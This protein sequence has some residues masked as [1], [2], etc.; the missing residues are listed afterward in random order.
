[1]RLGSKSNFLVHCK[2][3]KLLF[4]VDFKGPD[5]IEETNFSSAFILVDGRKSSNRLY[6]SN[7]RSPQQHPIYFTAFTLKSTIFYHSFIL[8]VG[9][10]SLNKSRV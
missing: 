7:A 5:K 2:R 10:P 8:A 3:I 1:M 6:K 4:A 9:I